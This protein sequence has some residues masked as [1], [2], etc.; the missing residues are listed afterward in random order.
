MRAETCAKKIGD[1]PTNSCRTMITGSE[2][3]HESPARADR[4]A[5]CARRSLAVHQPRTLVAGVQRPRARRGA[6]RAQ[7]AARAAEIRRDLRHEPRRV[8]HDSR[9]G[10]QAADRGARSCAAPTT[11]CCPRNISRRS[12]TPARLAAHADARSSTTNCCPRW[13]AAASASCASP[14]STTRRS[15]RSKHTFDDRVFP[16]LTPLAVDSGHPFPYISNLSL[17]LAVE[18]RRSDARR[19][20]RTALRAREDSADACRASCRSKRAAGRTTGFVLLEDLIAHHL[21]RALP[22][23]A[24]ARFVRRSA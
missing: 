22:R 3:R 15:A 10:D 8:L 24:R 18:L 5:R 23:H 1:H 13:S 4:A 6:R 20:R 7:P 14:S 12:R 16:V 17:S 11:G 21:R 2:P 19:R 9:R